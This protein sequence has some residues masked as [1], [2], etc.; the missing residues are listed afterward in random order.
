MAQRRV[1]TISD[2]RVRIHRNMRS[3]GAHDC[4]DQAL[5]HL[6]GGGTVRRYIKALYCHTSAYLT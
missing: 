4:L 3:P 2:L 1:P 6:Q 5:L